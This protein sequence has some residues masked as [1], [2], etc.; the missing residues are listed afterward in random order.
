MGIVRT[1]AMFGGLNRPAWAGQ[2]TIS[3]NDPMTIN[4]IA[5]S[6]PR[7]VMG[8]VVPVTTRGRP[9]AP[10]PLSGMVTGK[11]AGT[12]KGHLMALELGGPDVSENI[13]PQANLWQQS[14][15]WRA[16]ETN[17]LDLAMRWMGVAQ[18]YDPRAP[19]PAPSVAAF[20]SVGPY[21]EKDSK[22]QPTKY[23]GTVT[24][25]SIIQGTSGDYRPHPDEDTHVFYI[26]PQEVW[27][28]RGEKTA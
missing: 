16:I 23:I 18:V 4:T 2:V 8:I 28:G 24:K 15:G 19:I 7:R 9:S 26:G 6:N 22:G 27:W 5:A 17:V 20:F 10:V 12:D 25:I 11:A 14:G 1:W 21:P 3:D 13:V